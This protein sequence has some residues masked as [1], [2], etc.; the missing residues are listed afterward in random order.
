MECAW[1]RAS[2]TERADVQADVTERAAGSAGSIE[3][4][5]AAQPACWLRAAGLVS[6]VADLLP[7]AGERV[8][9]T[10]CGT[11]W[12]IAQSYAAAREAA[13]QGETDAFAASEMPVGRHYDRVLALSRS[14][15]TTEILELL[16]RLGGSVRTVAITADPA[17]P[18]AAAADNVIGLDFADEQS[19]V[20]TRF[21]TTELAL[22][23]AHLGQD[24]APM[25]AA[26]D[27]V[28]AA[29]LPPELVRARQF[30]F[31]GTGWTCG[32]ASEAALKLREAAG[33]WTEAYPAME[34]RHGPVAV[35]GPG[36]V[37]WLLGPAPAGLAAEVAAAGGLAWQPR[38]ALATPLAELVRAQRLAAAIAR[39]RGLDPDRPRNLT[40]SVILLPR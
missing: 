38:E 17:T 5:I 12:F 29:D 37:V 19:V 11:S 4:E 40:R 33:L 28:L 39:A 8:A 18:V 25:A 16:D 20:Q 32:L 35:T 13:G 24:I 15:T 1:R 3:A 6:E 23:L 9:V 10:G 14:G 36:S 21:A 2:V 22:L 27:E 34:Y 7:A 31:L 26:A 30:T